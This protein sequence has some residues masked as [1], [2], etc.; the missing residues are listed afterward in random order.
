MQIAVA[1]L[2]RIELI[3][4]RVEVPSGK[5]VGILENPGALPILSSFSFVYSIV[6]VFILTL[7][8]SKLWACSEPLHSLIASKSNYRAM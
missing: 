6:L 8:N 2:T 5:I 3:N 4:D 1:S 7:T